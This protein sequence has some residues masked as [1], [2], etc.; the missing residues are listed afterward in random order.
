[1]DKVTHKV[2]MQYE[3]ALNASIR[4]NHSQ[5]KTGTLQAYKFQLVN[6][7]GL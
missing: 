3:K 2:I 6:R 1:M 4:D 5:K 7:N